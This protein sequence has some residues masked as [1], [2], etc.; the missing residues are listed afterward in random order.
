[1]NFSYGDGGRGE[2]GLKEARDCAVRATATVLGIPYAE[3]HAK[4]KA[5]GRRDRCRF[6]FWRVTETLG[7][8]QRPD[9]TCRTLKSILPEL[10]RGRFIVRIAR[11]VFAVVDGVIHDRPQDAALPGCRVKMVYEWQNIV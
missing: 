6:K 10:S 9:L 2:S 11:H 5:L 1:M 3:A 4:L 8:Q 7:L